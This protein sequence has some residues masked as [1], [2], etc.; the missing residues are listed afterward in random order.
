MDHNDCLSPDAQMKKVLDIDRRAGAARLPRRSSRPALS[1]G[2]SAGTGHKG[3]EE[4]GRV[5]ATV[6]LAVGSSDSCWQNTG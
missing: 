3:S 5:D 6:S 4:P 1:E 2:E